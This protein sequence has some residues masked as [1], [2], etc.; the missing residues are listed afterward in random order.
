LRPEEFAATLIRELE[1][2]PVWKTA[3]MRKIRK[4]YSKKL[5][6]E[7][8]TYVMDVAHSMI[9]SGRHRWIAYEL[10]RD[11]PAA[12]HSLDRQ[13]LEELG[14]E[15]NSWASVDSFARTL[16]GPAW[17]EGLI[18]SETIRDWACSSDR[19][20]R[21]TAL[22]STV[23]LNV[24]SRGGSGDVGNTLAICEML[25]EDQ[26][27]MVVKALSWALRELVVHDPVAVQGFISAH[28]EV[29]AARIKREVGNKLRTGLKNP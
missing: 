12:F 14:Y 18:S 19:W 17:R 25:V 4:K 26:D 8:G 22:V 11:Y 28:E 7:N 10:I 2:L 24:R 3:P 13:K 20:W 23:A 29:L 15:L 21:R 5:K 6:T 16:S 9:D 27:D 1:S